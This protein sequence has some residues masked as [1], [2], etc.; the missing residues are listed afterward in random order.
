MKT[1]IKNPD[2]YIGLLLFAAM[3]AAISL[4]APYRIGFKEQL[5]IFYLSPERLSWYLSNPGLPAAIGGDWLTQFYY[6]NVLGILITS[7][8]LL[9]LW[10]GI[11]R[12]FRLAGA[13]NPSYIVALLP[14]TA[15]GACIVLPN[16][17]VSELLGLLFA[18]WAASGICHMRQ[19]RIRSV[20]IGTAVPVLFILAGG[21]AV[22][23]A[24][25]C[26]L[27]RTGSFRQNV[28]P[29][30]IGLAV[31][32]FLARLYNL[33]PIQALMYPVV[34]VNILPR[35]PVLLLMPLSVIVCLVV[36]YLRKPLIPNVATALCTVIIICTSFRDP[37]ME[38]SYRIGTIAYKTEDW[39]QIRSEAEKRL[40]IIYGLFYR[41]LSY[42]REGRLPDKLADCDQGK[43]SDG[44]FLITGYNENYLSTYFFID[45]LLEMGDLSQAID[46][47][48][49]AQ[50]ST[51]G[52]C[53]TRIIR[54]L[55]EISVTAAD[56]PVALKYLYILS[57]TR[58]HR[59]WAE[60]LIRCIDTDSIP[61]K[62]LTWRSRTSVKDRFYELGAIRSSLNSI[63]VDCPANKVAIDY[64]MC[65][66][67]L[68]GNLDAFK[69]L[70]NQFW[71]DGLDRN[72]KVPELYK[73]AMSA[74]T[75]N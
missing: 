28:L 10:V 72:H 73:A 21:N 14:V 13:E 46:C 4:F 27:I 29:V 15:A 34:M 65:S 75:G 48:L 16:Y 60:N 42:A 44:L 20:C 55:A 49:M 57:R 68:D 53:P 12:L 6:N 2:S 70:Y 5:G 24:I 71:A 36:S 58:M 38:F 62:Y 61:E 30:I 8:L 52:H 74:N 31:T 54:R 43:N 59:E 9:S 23:F 19:S 69:S 25:I 17:P 39:N 37:V 41:N 67:L 3:V 32:F 47:A 1:K 35:V 22:T 11:R 51:P 56:Y 63:I 7:I 18:V 45:A 64:L 40:D 50:A 66:C 26:L 33:T